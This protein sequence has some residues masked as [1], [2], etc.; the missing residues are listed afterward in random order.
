MQLCSDGHDEV[1]FVGSWD[2][3]CPACA[4]LEEQRKDMQQ[5]IDDLQKE[6]DNH[7][8]EES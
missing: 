5:E 2:K 7:V 8:C 4:A 3:D 1:C 6:I